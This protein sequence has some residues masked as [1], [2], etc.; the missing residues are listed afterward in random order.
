MKRSGENSS[1]R[2]LLRSLIKAISIS[3]YKIFSHNSND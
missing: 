1:D 3:Y 2:F